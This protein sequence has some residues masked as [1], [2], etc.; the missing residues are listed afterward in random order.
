MMHLASSLASSITLAMNCIQPVGRSFSGSPNS[1]GQEKNP[2]KRYEYHMSQEFLPCEIKNPACNVIQDSWAKVNGFKYTPVISQALHEEAHKAMMAGV[3]NG[4]DISSGVSTASHAVETYL[5]RIAQK[6]KLPEQIVQL[7][8]TVSDR[9]TG[10]LIAKAVEKV[11]N[12]GY[13]AAMPVKKEVDNELEFDY[14]MRLD[15]SSQSPFRL[16]FFDDPKTNLRVLIRPLILIHKHKIFNKSIV[17]QALKST[18][19]KRPLLIVAESVE[20]KL[21]ASVVQDRESHGTEVYIVTSREKK[22]NDAAILEDLAIFTGGQVV[23]EETDMNYILSMFGSCREIMIT[24]HSTTIIIGSGNKENIEKRRQELISA[25][26]NSES[27]PE[28]KFLSER[29]KALSRGAAILKVGVA[30][31]MEEMFK[32]FIRVA[33]SVEVVNSAIKTGIIPGGGV[34]LLHASK[35]LDKLQVKN[36]G[37]KYG[38]QLFQHALKIPVFSIAST[39]GFDGSLVIEKLLE[40]EEIDLGYDPTSGEYVD[41]IK[42][43]NMDPAGI[44]S[45]EL[46]NLVSE[47]MEDVLYARILHGLP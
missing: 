42:S 17:E 11:G 14:A 25:I 33:N 41:M 22:E 46:D 44:V 18:N 16:S 29:V 2:F 38:V 43:G 13:I 27:T 39:A 1:A 34:A 30:G 20:F 8:A 15:W 40:Q 21:L 23:T 24:L 45:W 37:E 31:S 12:D 35:E 10:E 6:I 28:I 3:L 4:E 7:A 5:E 32:K 19:N 36:S 47:F 26:C 9:E